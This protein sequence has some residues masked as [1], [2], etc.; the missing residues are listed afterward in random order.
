[1]REGGDGGG[2]Q[3]TQ[4]SIELVELTDRNALNVELAMERRRSTGS[5][6]QVTRYVHYTQQ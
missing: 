1:M 6:L 2:C 4:H 3:G 5:A